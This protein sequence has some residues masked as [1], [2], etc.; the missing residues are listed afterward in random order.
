MEESMNEEKQDQ[1]DS[2]SLAAADAEVN[3][4]PPEA[5]NRQ[6]PELN[7]T[8]E[9]DLQPRLPLRSGLTKG[10]RLVRKE[11]AAL[12]V[13]L[14]EAQRLLLLDTWRRNQLPA[15][16]FANLVGISEHF[17]HTSQTK[18]TPIPVKRQSGTGF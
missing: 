4:I 9:E 12:Q 3:E 15:T 18:L 10:R 17:L 5:R 2:I 1:Y 7:T 16:D 11:E 13:A 14:T 8:G 6:D